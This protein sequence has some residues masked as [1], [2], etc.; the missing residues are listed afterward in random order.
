MF[1]PAYF[2]YFTTNI[3]TFHLL[4]MKLFKFIYQTFIPHSRACDG[5]L[6]HL[7]Y[8]PQCASS[9]SVFYFTGKQFP[10]KQKRPAILP[11]SSIMFPPAYFFYFTTNIPTFHLLFMKLFKFIYQTFI[12][13]SR[14]CD[15]RLRH[16]PYTPQCASSRSVFYFT[17]KQFPVKQKRPAK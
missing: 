16:L 14:A 1:P 5:R 3:P 9:R 2:F 17:G 11:S 10:V 7:P 15:G 6:R 4:F 13:H 8:T 12:P